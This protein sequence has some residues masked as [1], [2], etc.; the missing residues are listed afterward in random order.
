MSAY[1]DLAEIILFKGNIEM[2]VMKRQLLKAKTQMAQIPETMEAVQ[3]KVCSTVT[4][5]TSKVLVKIKSAAG[6]IVV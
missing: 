5:A 3:H 6:E 1:E 4:S 2:L